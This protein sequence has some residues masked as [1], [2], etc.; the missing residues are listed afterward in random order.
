M[1]KDH[2]E[3]ELKY[4]PPYQR[5]LVEA[6]IAEGDLE[7][8]RAK[9]E[10]L[11]VQASACRK[12]AERRAAESENDAKTGEGE[13]GGTAGTTPASFTSKASP[14]PNPSGSTKAPQQSTP[15]ST[16]APTSNPGPSLSEQEQKVVSLCGKQQ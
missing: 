6:T 15:P 16:T 2:P 14:T 11:S 4:L 12:Q 1:V 8:A 3:I 10:E 13:A 5:K 9:I 7:G